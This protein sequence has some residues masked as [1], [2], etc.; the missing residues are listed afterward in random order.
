MGNSYDVIIV[1]A[2]HNGLS[3][4]IKLKKN[5]PELRILILEQFD[6]IGGACRTSF[7]F[8][9]A[10]K[11]G[12]SPGAYLLGLMPQSIIEEYGLKFKTIRRNP[13]YFLP[14]KEKGRYLALGSNSGKNSESIKAFSSEKDLIAYQRM[15][16]NISQI[17]SSILPAWF[18]EPDTLEMI[19]LKSFAI[20]TDRKQFINLCRGSVADYLN[21]W[22][23]ENNLIKAM[24]A[25]D[26]I[27]GTYGDFDTPGTGFNFLIHNMCHLAGADGTWMLV[28][29]GMGA[30]TTEMARVAK[31]LGVEIRTN[32]KVQ[33]LI[34]QSGQVKGVSISGSSESEIFADVIV[35]NSDP[36]TIMDLIDNNDRPRELQEKLI[37][38]TTLKGTS[39][40]VNL[41]MAGLPKFICC[42]D[43][44]EPYTGTTH[45]LPD[46]SEVFYKLKQAFWAVR[47]SQLPDFP[48]I[49][50]YTQTVLDPS[51]RGGTTDHNLALFVQL[52]PN[53]FRDG[54]SW[55]DHKEPFVQHL[56]SIMDVFSPGFS[57]L[58]KEHYT[59]TPLDIERLF[60]IK[61]GHILHANHSEM[62]DKRLPYHSGISGLYFCGAAC[63]PGGGV[64]GIPGYNSANRITQDLF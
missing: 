45:I 22:G 27:I 10:P 60:G 19:A 8:K 34:I 53:S 33:N 17:A 39:M 32:V 21:Q 7:P 44:Q 58:V 43:G 16:A 52:V 2:G 11:V 25:L 15:Q 23:F 64:S 63:H 40:K 51:L 3:C 29:G 54:S 1:G 26:G 50:C 49:E 56:L 47:R 31:S 57:G 41:C 55:D 48:V 5:K 46:E 14:T 38:L 4:A 18:R 13:H 37:K 20:D 62:A 36:G 61:G 28:Q 35:V 9:S 42:P 12:T 30:V 59:L 24:L 6:Q